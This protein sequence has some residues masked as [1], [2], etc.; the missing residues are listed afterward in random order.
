MHALKIPGPEE[1]FE[2]I[3]HINRCW[4]YRLLELL[5]NCD[6]TLVSE[7]R[8]AARMQLETLTFSIA[9][10]NKPRGLLVSEHHRKNGRVEESKFR[11]AL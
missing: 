11:P 7:C 3:I 1:L 10:S 4:L 6:G 5:E 8:K 9:T 2:V